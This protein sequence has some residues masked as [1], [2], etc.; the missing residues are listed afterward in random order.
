MNAEKEV[1]TTTARPH[2]CFLTIAWIAGFGCGVAGLH[3]LQN[4]F[5]PLPQPMPE[6][7]RMDVERM[8]FVCCCCGF[9]GVWFTWRIW[10]YL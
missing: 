1:S 3:M 6:E 2:G 7:L 9:L 5:F 8:L 10:K 4:F